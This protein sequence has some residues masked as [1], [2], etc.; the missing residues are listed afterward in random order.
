MSEIWDQFRDDYPTMSFADKRAF[1]DW[2]AATYPEQRYADVKRA[3]NAFSLIAGGHLDV[4]E[5]GGW[6]G[7]LAASVMRTTG[8]IRSWTNYDLVAVPQ[9]CDYRGY[10]LKVL[11][12]DLWSLDRVD[13]DV[14]VSTHTI[15]HLSAEELAKL[16]R[17]LMPEFVYLEAPLP[18]VGPVSW[19][20][21]EAAHVL[22]L[23]WDGVEKLLI[24][25]GYTSRL[26]WFDLDF[27]PVGFPGV[28]AGLW[29]RP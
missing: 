15:E 13:A 16:F 2:V 24:D 3:L 4:I 17:W 26:A 20:G 29:R 22:E 11:N 18:M 12:D 6:D 14:F 23:G 28:G 8:D 21:V 1:Y 27:G 25:V 19:R 9:E 5:L 7:A 10:H